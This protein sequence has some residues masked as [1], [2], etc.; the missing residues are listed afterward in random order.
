[1][2]L[3]AEVTKVRRSGEAELQLAVDACELW[4]NA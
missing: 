2:L 3:A 1:L 4:C